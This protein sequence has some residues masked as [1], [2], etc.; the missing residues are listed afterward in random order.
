MN[1]SLLVATCCLHGYLLTSSLIWFCFL[2]VFG[3]FL[4]ESRWRLLYR[5]VCI[6][7]T[8][9]QWFRFCVIPC[10]TLWCWHS[11]SCWTLFSWGCTFVRTRIGMAVEVV[12]YCISVCMFLADKLCSTLHPPPHSWSPA[13]LAVFCSVSSLLS[14]VCMLQILIESILSLNTGLKLCHYELTVQGKIVNT[15]SYLP[16]VTDC[17]CCLWPLCSPSLLLW[18]A[19]WRMS[20]LVEV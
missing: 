18:R 7:S 5:W 16:T 12:S 8:S 6:H 10:S 3:L 11:P 1:L 9:C 4:I 15:V 20:V 2:L 14:Y 13:Y 17:F 19:L